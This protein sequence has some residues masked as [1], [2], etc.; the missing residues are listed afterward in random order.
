MTSDGLARKMAKGDVSDSKG[1]GLSTTGITV[2]LVDAHDSSD[3]GPSDRITLD[4]TTSSVSDLAHE[5]ASAERAA[6]AEI[7]AAPRRMLDEA[8]ANLV[9]PAEMARDA[10]ATLGEPAVMAREMLLDLGETTRLAAQPLGELFAPTDAVRSVDD[11]LGELRAEAE[12]RA[13]REAENQAARDAALFAMAEEIRAV[14]EGLA[15]VN[16][17]LD[18]SNEHADAQTSRLDGLLDFARHQGVATHVVVF[19]ASAG[20]VLALLAL[21]AK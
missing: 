19:L 20:V 6:L 11:M 12:E 21:V 16:E 4:V 2:P 10:L 8:M 9:K 14:N 15:A 7:L 5:L 17:R 18:T 13:R 1:Q 3:A